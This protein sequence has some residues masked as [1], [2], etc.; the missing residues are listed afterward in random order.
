MNECMYGCAARTRVY[1]A[2]A[3]LQ[4][5]GPSAPGLDGR[6]KPQVVTSQCMT[7]DR[8][9][10]VRGVNG[11]SWRWGARGETRPESRGAAF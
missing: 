3:L 9:G 1:N 2:G 5:P 8:A 7:T 10:D 4:A 11:E 6:L